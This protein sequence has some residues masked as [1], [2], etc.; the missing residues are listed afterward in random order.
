MKNPSST[1]ASTSSSG[2]S[3]STPAPSSHGLR[4]QLGHLIPKH[5]LFQ[6]RLEIEQLSNVPLIK[7]EFGV[8]W[9]FKGV[10]SGSGLLGKMKGGSKTWS[11]QGKGKGRATAIGLGIG[12]TEEGELFDEAGSTH[13][14]TQGTTEDDPDADTAEE[15][16]PHRHRS[17]E[18]LRATNASTPQLNGHDTPNPPPQ[19]PAPIVHSVPATQSEARGMTPWAELQNYNVK[20]SHSVNVAVQMDVHRE[21]GDLLPNELKLVVMQVCV[22]SLLRRIHTATSP[23]PRRFGNLVLLTSCVC[24]HSPRCALRPVMR[25]AKAKRVSPSR[26]L[27]ASRPRRFDNNLIS[28]GMM[29]DNGIYGMPERSEKACQMK[30]GSPCRVGHP[31]A[32]VRGTPRLF[33]NYLRRLFVF[34][35]GAD[36][37]C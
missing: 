15:P 19:T 2:A 33:L 9:K 4:S 3:S 8:R 17:F 12:V 30:Y 22:H 23:T 16:N 24:A 18:Y 31:A 21:T 13:G 32:T 7:G 25:T 1:S 26:S 11:G 29:P 37:V 10:Q 35:F 14:S 5:A 28:R 27:S 34:E 6:V 20:W 36:I